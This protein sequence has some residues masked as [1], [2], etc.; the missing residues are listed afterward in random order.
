MKKILVIGATG[1]LGKAIVQKLAG[2]ADVIEA[3]FS[4]PA[5]PVDLADPSALK[6]LFEKVGKVDAI[7]CTAGVAHFK[8]F[9]ETQDA[10][11]QFAIANKMMG[12]INTVRFGAEYLNEGGAIVLTT[13]TLAQTPLP[14]SAIVSAVNA[15]VEGAIRAFSLELDKVRINAVSPGWIT[16]TLAAMGMDTAAGMPAEDVAQFYVDLVEQSRSG[17]IVVAAR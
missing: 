3:S 16:E 10:D 5:N 13:G 8:P 2:T 14:G 6:A 1:L 4:H 17:D 11:W 15:A 9:A 7:I 12:Q